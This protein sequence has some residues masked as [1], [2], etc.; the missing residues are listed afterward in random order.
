MVLATAGRVCLTTTRWAGSLRRRC[1]G[2]CH[3]P[4]Q[5]ASG[6]LKH[7]VALYTQVYAGPTATIA[8]QIGSMMARITMVN[9]GVSLGRFARSSGVKKSAP[10]LV[11]VS[12]VAGAA[13]AANPGSSQTPLVQHLIAGVETGG[14]NEAIERP[15]LNSI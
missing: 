11:K 1:A 6:A 4:S 10:P 12:A 13:T 15:S 7:A 9:A 2:A 8:Y 3:L 5:S 14:E